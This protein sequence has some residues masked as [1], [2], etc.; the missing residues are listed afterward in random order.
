M[1]MLM[2]AYIYLLGFAIGSRSTWIWVMIWGIAVGYDWLLVQPMKIAV[3]WVVLI[4]TVKPGLLFQHTIVKDRAEY[5][6]HR[7]YGLVRTVHAAVQ[8]FNA[9]CRAARYFPDLA[10]ARFLISLHDYD[11]R[12]EYWYWNYFTWSAW[13][14]YHFCRTV[15]WT[16]FAWI[17]S[18]FPSL[19]QEFA[20]DLLVVILCCLLGIGVILLTRISSFVAIGLGA[21]IFFSGV[22]LPVTLF[23]SSRGVK[24][25]Q[26]IP[27]TAEEDQ[28]DLE[29]PVIPK[30]LV[31]TTT[32]MTTDKYLLNRPDEEL[33]HLTQKQQFE[34]IVD[35]PSR[36]TF[37]EFKAAKEKRYLKMIRKIFNPSYKDSSDEEEEE[38]PIEA[39]PVPVVETPAA[40]AVTESSPREG[41]KAEDPVSTT[42]E[43]DLVVE[44]YASPVKDKALP[45]LKI[46]IETTED[47]PP[48]KRQ[49][50]DS[51]DI[52]SLLSPAHLPPAAI[53]V[54]KKKVMGSKNRIIPKHKLKAVEMLRKLQ[55]QMETDHSHDLTAGE[56]PIKPTTAPSHPQSDSEGGGDDFSEF[57]RSK[58]SAL[59]AV[60]GQTAS[61]PVRDGGRS[62]KRRERGDQESSGGG[63]RRLGRDLSRRKELKSKIFDLMKKRELLQ[64]DE[65]YLQRINSREAMMTSDTSD[66]EDFENPRYPPAE[67]A[68]LSDPERRKGSKSPTKQRSK[69]ALSTS[70]SSRS[71]S[72]E[73]R[74]QLLKSKLHAVEVLKSLQHKMQEE[75]EQQL[76]IEKSPVRKEKSVTS[77]YGSASAASTEYFLPLDTEDDR[78]EPSSAVAG[79]PNRTNKKKKSSRRLKKPLEFS[80]VSSSAMEDSEGGGDSPIR[81]QSL[82]KPVSSEPMAKSTGDPEFS[83]APIVASSNTG[84]DATVSAKKTKKRRGGREG[85]G[86]LKI[87]PSRF[88]ISHAAL[89]AMTAEEEMKLAAVTSSPP[90]SA[91]A[92]SRER[93]RSGGEGSSAMLSDV[94]EE[95]DYRLSDGEGRGGHRR[96]RQRQM[97]ERDD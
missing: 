42:P 44:E 76:T 71:R 31:V 96:T 22:A 92:V 63:T 90:R 33:L 97:S 23:W 60:S 34:V 54:A 29:A 69:A 64:Q 95:S 1:M 28:G 47:I 74:R 14:A 85:S 27:S 62:R 68:A 59:L 75:D 57:R 72:K 46:Q 32:S 91:S 94:G 52:P 17:F 93:G 49:P 11:L 80:D 25:T 81:F 79:L 3:K 40:V 56:V 26:V 82:S 51:E 21:L 19:F 24:A 38:V 66:R 13:C 43:K 35:A 20:I 50:S 6:L 30:D 7:R 12:T 89:Q 48:E 88:Q 67:I 78:S 41:E 84:H 65:S 45:N 5:I 87:D 37:Q 83:F 53:S 55:Q 10:A 73:N 58:S 8:H 39:P 61:S 16:L 4:Y 36:L 15:S 9:A 70:P 77:G 86:K 18:V 2:I